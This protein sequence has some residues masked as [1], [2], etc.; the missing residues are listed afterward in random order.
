MTTRRAI[1]LLTRAVLEWI[2]LLLDD[3]EPTKPTE[4]TQPT[5]PA[6]QPNPEFFYTIPDDEPDDAELDAALQVGADA[7][8]TLLLPISFSMPTNLPLDDLVALSILEP[9]RAEAVRWLLLQHN[10]G[11]E[12]RPGM[13]PIQAWLEHT[14]KISDNPYITLAV[15]ANQVD[16]SQ[17]ARRWLAFLQ[18]V[19]QPAKGADED[20]G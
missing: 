9:E 5:Q 13:T 4:P 8:L 6:Q 1:L 10:M 14:R 2:A 20:Q 11:I 18:G 3:G 19:N 16:L 15:L 12:R 7:D 17:D